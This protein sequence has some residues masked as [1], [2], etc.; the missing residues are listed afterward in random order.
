MHLDGELFGGRK[1][2]QSTVSIVKTPEHQHWNK[3]VYHVSKSPTTK[4]RLFYII[5]D[6]IKTHIFHLNL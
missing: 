2:F 1:K 5:L 3:I 4:E 6:V